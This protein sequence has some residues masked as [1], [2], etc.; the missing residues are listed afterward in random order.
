MSSGL[1]ILALHGSGS[2][3]AC[4]SQQTKYFQEALEE[5]L[6]RQSTRFLMG[7]FSEYGFSWW[8]MKEGERSSNAKE[9]I[10]LDRASG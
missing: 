10:G 7:L 4:F 9:L 3:G 2:H 1:R 8:K 5:V 6:L